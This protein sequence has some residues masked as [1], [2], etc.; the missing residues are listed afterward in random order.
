MRGKYKPGEKALLLVKNDLFK[1]SNAYVVCL[2]KCFIMNGK[3]EKAWNRYSKIKNSNE[4]F[5]VAQ[6]IANDSYRMGHFFYAAKAFDVLEK[7][8]TNFWEGKRGAC[9]LM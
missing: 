6:L 5:H 8:D 1:K 9:I 7:Q 3:P 4:S 2:C